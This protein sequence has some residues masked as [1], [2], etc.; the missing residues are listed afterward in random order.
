MIIYQSIPL[1]DQKYDALGHAACN[2]I[3]SRVQSQ[4]KFYRLDYSAIENF[5]EQ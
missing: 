1:Q 2:F 3:A 5:V 4:N